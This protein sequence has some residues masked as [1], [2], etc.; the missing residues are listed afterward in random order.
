MRV[1]KELQKL[2]LAIENDPYPNVMDVDDPK[3][4]MKLSIV[5]IMT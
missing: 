3:T 5:L 1:H 4:M 2:N